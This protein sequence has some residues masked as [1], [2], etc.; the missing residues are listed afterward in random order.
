M[1]S[2]LRDKNQ[3]SSVWVFKEK[4]GGVK[5]KIIVHLAD[6]NGNCFGDF[7][8]CSRPLNLVLRLSP[9]RKMNVNVHPFLYQT[10]IRWSEHDRFYMSAPGVPVPFFPGEDDSWVPVS[11]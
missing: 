4:S 8:L 2:L 3:T 5:S 6:I 1:F 10:V 7:R 11:C 9:L